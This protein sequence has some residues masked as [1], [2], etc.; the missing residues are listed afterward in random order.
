MAKIHK[1]S[2]YII[3]PSRAGQI[4]RNTIPLDLK[5]TTDT[6]LQHF[7]FQSADISPAE[8]AELEKENCDLTL[9][10]AHFRAKPSVNPEGRKV[11]IGGTYRHFKIGKLV[12]VL[13]VSRDTESPDALCV[14]YRCADGRIWHR[15]Y[16][17]FLSRVDRE[18]Y[19]DATQEYRFEL[20]EP[21]P[22][23]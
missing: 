12:K 18:K 5:E 22:E 19:P 11:V 2:G 23:A 14:I 6:I 1:F 17:M 16:D 8:L 15:P 3:D 7:H 20:V 4:F 9:C 10:E 13:A 21:Q